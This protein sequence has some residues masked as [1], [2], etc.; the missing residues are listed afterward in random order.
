[1]LQLIKIVAEGPDAVSDIN[2]LPSSTDYPSSTV[3]IQTLAYANLSF[4]VLAAF[5]AVMGKQWLNSFKSLRVQGPLEERGF[6]RQKRLDGLEYWHLQT[7]LR[8]FLVLLQISLLLFGLSLSANM[9]TQQRTISSVIITATALGILFYVATIVISV[10]HPDSP[11][12][13][14]GS[15]IAGAV[16]RKISKAFSNAFSGALSY[17]LRRASF[18][19]YLKYRRLRFKLTSTPNIVFDR[20]SPIRWILETSTNPEV[21]EAAAAMVP[22][23]QWSPKID[24]SAAYVR[25]VDNLAT[26][27]GRPELFVT[28]GKAMAH[29]HV[30]SAVNELPNH[31]KEWRSW[32][33][34]GDK[35]SFICDAFMDARR[36]Y[37]Q[38]KNPEHGSNQW[39]NQADAR[40]ALRTVVVYGGENHLLHP[41]REILIWNGDLRWQHA[42]GKTPCCE[43]FDWLIDYL[44]D[45]VPDETDDNT[46]GDYPLILSTMH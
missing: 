37:A 12:Q 1:M 21:V 22:L 46:E 17:A 19:I 39:K 27:A 3:W 35:R 33:S 31:R 24:A 13:T 15:V 11:F 23:V 29:L 25:L 18:N 26:C 5:G 36:A 2:G 8:A 9:W 14:A 42:N 20:S 43:E 41:D 7:V 34:W 44:V 38:L 4:S 28:C 6:Q 30:Q 10:L 16:S 40:T 45:R 32:H